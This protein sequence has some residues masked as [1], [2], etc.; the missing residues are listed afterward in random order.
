MADPTTTLDAP[1]GLL[2]LTLIDDD[3]LSV[4]GSREA[5]ELALLDERILDWA[6]EHLGP[7]ERIDADAGEHGEED[8][9]EIWI[10]AGVPQHGDIV[11]AD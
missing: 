1:G 4:R 8:I 9:E 11:D 10:L 7:V 2:T 6:S 3:R 5:V